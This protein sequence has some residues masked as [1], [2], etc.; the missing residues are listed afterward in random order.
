MPSGVVFRPSEGHR[1]GNRCVRCGLV[2]PTNPFTNSTSFYCPNPSCRN[3]HVC[4][5]RPDFRIYHAS[6]DDGTILRS[7]RCY[8][9]DHT[10]DVPP[11]AIARATVLRNSFRNPSF[12]CPY[13]IYPYKYYRCPNSHPPPI[14]TTPITAALVDDDDDDFSPVPIRTPASGSFINSLPMR[15][16]FLSSSD[17]TQPCSICMEDFR[18]DTDVFVTINELPCGHCF[19]KGC[20]V[21]W[22]QR[23]NTC[24]LCRYKCPPAAESMPRSG[25]VS[26]L[27]STSIAATGS[28]DHPRRGWIDHQSTNSTGE[29]SIGSMAVD[30]DGDT[31]MADSSQTS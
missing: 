21:E 25:P 12:H 13:C 27:I 28:S 18:R 17:S 5:Y 30:E 15:L 2:F 8:N 6:R 9:C 20:I 11:I 1:R 10:F 31:L 19:H 3:P 4:L 29:R 24:P 22:L 23:S 7:I 16:M 26:R 14:T